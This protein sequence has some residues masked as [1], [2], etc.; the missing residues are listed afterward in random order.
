VDGAVLADKPVHHLSRRS[1]SFWAK[2]AL[3][4]FRISLARRSSLARIRRTRL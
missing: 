1:S 4:S 2:D 3:A